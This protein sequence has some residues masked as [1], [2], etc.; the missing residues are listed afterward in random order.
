VN[1]EARQG[2]FVIGLVQ[3]NK[4]AWLWQEAYGENNMYTFGLLSPTQYGFRK[5]K[6]TRDCLVMSTTDI[7][8]SFEMKKQT[9]AAFLDMRGSTIMFS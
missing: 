3:T 4:F 8:T 2:S 7:T 6:G 1:C 9:V 5:G